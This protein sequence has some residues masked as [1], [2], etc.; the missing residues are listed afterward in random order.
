LV[1]NFFDADVS[2]SALSQPQR[3]TLPAARFS[4]PNFEKSP[5]YMVDISFNHVCPRKIH[6]TARYFFLLLRLQNEILGIS[7]G[8]YRQVVDVGEKSASDVP[9]EVKADEIDLKS[10]RS[11]V[12]SSSWAKHL[13]A[14]QYLLMSEP[15]PVRNQP[16]SSLKISSINKK[17]DFFSFLSLICRKPMSCL[18]MFST[19]M[20]RISF[21]PSLSP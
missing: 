21:P 13:W 6:L 14:V 9:T 8:H 19:P 7:F 10:I 15:G 5:F 2:F 17:S 11:S 4:D 3:P 18:D 16:P 20:Y 12:S 1:R